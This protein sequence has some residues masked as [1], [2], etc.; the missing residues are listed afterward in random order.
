MRFPVLLLLLLLSGLAGAAEPLV[1]GLA[2]NI[3][4]EAERGL[5]QLPAQGLVRIGSQDV[6]LAPGLQI[7]DTYNRIIL[8]S[9]LAAPQR[10]KYLLDAQGQLFRVWILTAAEAQQP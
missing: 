1:A 2:R 8:S 7:R 4:A 6:H 10:V 3:P 9:S 5:M